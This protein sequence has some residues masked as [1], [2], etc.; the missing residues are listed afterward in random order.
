MPPIYFYGNYDMTNT[1]LLLDRRIR[2]EL[3]E[4]MNVACLSISNGNSYSDRF[5]RF[6]QQER[7]CMAENNSLPT[8]F[9]RG[10]V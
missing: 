5:A 2:S 4:I 7:A 10:I 3:V 9:E 8:K 6:H 1:I